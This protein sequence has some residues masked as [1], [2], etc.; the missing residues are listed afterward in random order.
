ML[1]MW[2]PSVSKRQSYHIPGKGRAC[3]SHQEAQKVMQE[4]TTQKREALQQ[5]IA[6]KQEKKFGLDSEYTF[7]DPKTYCWHCNEN[8][9]SQ[10]A[11]A[12]VLLSCCQ[13]IE[14]AEGRVPNVLNSQDPV[15]Q[16][17]VEKLDHRGIIELFALP[18]DFP[19]WKI[20]QL[21]KEPSL[22]DL[23]NILKKVVLCVKCAK[24]FGFF[25][26]TGTVE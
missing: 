12:E 7:R 8:S 19:K 13:E 10:T 5:A 18:Q 17:V 25:W 15:W 16:K 9:V 21:C 6:K 3:K 2:R 4:K 20:K 23:A 26:E 1:H 22:Q 11:L 14:K 24:E